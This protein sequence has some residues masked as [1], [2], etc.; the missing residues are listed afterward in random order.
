MPDDLIYVSA[1]ENLN[2]LLSM[3][4]ADSFT[5]EAKRE[6]RCKSE[7]STQRKGNG[8]AFEKAHAHAVR[9]EGERNGCHRERQGHEHETSYAISFLPRERVDLSD[10]EA[11]HG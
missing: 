4:E 6:P 5:D 8:L 2:D 10:I 3:M 1:S 11:E 9:N 7:H